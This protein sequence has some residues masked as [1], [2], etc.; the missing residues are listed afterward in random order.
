MGSEQ[1]DTPAVQLDTFDAR[2]IARPHAFYA[3]LR[4]HA[5]IAWIPQ[6][7]AW[8]LTRHD[9]VRAV[10]RD[11]EQ[12]SSERDDDRRL[13][14][15]AGV[16]VETVAPR[17]TLTMLGADRPDHTRLRKLLTADFAPANIGRLQGH[18]EA[19]VADLLK[20]L[21]ATEVFDVAEDL[22]VPLPVTVIAEL[23]GIPPERGRQFKAWSDAV[24]EPLRPDATAEQVQA[25]NAQVVAF[26]EYLQA[27]IDERHDH[28]TDDFI[29]RLV[30]AHDDGD[31]LTDAE[32]LGSVNLLLL[33]G[34]E[35][36]TNL[37]SNAVLALCRFPE[38]QQELRDHPERIDAAVEEFLRYDGSVQFT[39][40][41]AVGPAELH[42]QAI[43][44][45]EHVVVGLASANRDPAV[46]EDPDVLR[47][48]RP[49]SKH[50]GF[51]NWIHICLGQY[52][53]RMETKAAL[54]G[55]LAAWPPFEL[56]VPDDE[57]Q[58]RP[59]FN[60]RGPKHLPIRKA[61]IRDR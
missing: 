58:Y 16:S 10:L 49:G 60:L 6:L 26:R 56:A 53:A 36:T 2:M 39:V 30:A 25:R 35:T 29:G 45:E 55:L 19:I 54:L 31:E 32:L 42:G 24:I 21:P 38:R 27:R 7:N 18:I 22:S 5:P 61:G 44:P 46:F 12:W 40:R 17:G 14:E 11:H 51:G 34:N 13:M 50:L 57:V 4:E 41:R 47:F 48:D 43:K 3:H 15:L 20:D 23:L 37:I 28:P 9:D 8:I 33:A 52:L 59:S 1:T